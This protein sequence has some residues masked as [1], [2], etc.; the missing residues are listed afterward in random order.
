[1]PRM[2]AWSWELC[3]SVP[4]WSPSSL[5]IASLAGAGLVV[6]FALR[7]GGGA[8]SAGDL[9]LFAAVAVS[10]IGYAFSGRLAAQMPGWEVI[11]WALVIGLPISLPAAVLT[12]P[13]DLSQIAPKPWLALL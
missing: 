10:A 11:S 12:M 1:M 5:P 6:A 9:L 2:V 7:Q 3:P 8:L 13:A 4:P